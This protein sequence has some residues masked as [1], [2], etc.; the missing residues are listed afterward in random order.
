MP[1][2]DEAAGTPSPTQP[3]LPP[4]SLIIA[5]RNRPDL[6]EAAVA[7]ILAG[8]DVPAE[9]II[10]DQS[11]APHPRLSCLRTGRPCDIRYF[12]TRS[13][14][15]S[16]ANNRGVAAARHDLLVFTH[17]DVL[18]PPRWFGAIVRALAAAGSRDVITG[19]VLPTEAETPGGL[20]PTFVVD[21]VAKVYEGRIGNDVLFP[22]NMAMRR[23]VIRDVGPFDERLGPGTRFPA[24]EDNDFG[25]RL[26]EAGYRI[27]YVPEAAL[28]HRAWR[29]DHLRLRWLYGR[30]QGGFFAK[31]LGLRD[32]YMTNRMLRALAHYLRRALSRS[33]RAPRLAA[34]DALYAAGI[35]FGALEWLLTHR[36]LR[37]RSADRF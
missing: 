11:D 30:G 29:S 15:L 1:R 9:L 26:L 32:R 3:P 4:A 22:L 21:D 25:L 33:R 34:G 2:I 19:R 36:M 13:V 6:L 16:R 35:A 27:A 17:D 31:H 5:S 14:G 24:G 7:S 12:W 23:S 28:F 20:V 10:V 37:L 18:A 8:D